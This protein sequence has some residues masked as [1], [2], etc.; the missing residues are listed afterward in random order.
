MTPESVAAKIHPAC[1]LAAGHPIPRSLSSELALTSVPPEGWLAQFIEESACDLSWPLEEKEQVIKALKKH[2]EGTY[3]HTA[4]LD[5]GLQIIFQKLRLKDESGRFVISKEKRVLILT[6]LFEDVGECTP[7]FHCRVNEAL[8]SLKPINTIEE[9][10]YHYRYQLVD[11]VARPISERVKWGFRVHQYNAVFVLA[12]HLQLGVIPPSLDDVHSQPLA[13]RDQIDLLDSFQKYYRPIHLVEAIKKQLRQ[14][15]GLLGYAGYNKDGYT[16]G[17][18]API[19]RYFATF[20]EI[21]LSERDIFLF[22][23]DSAIVDIQWKKVEESIVPLLREK[24]LLNMSDSAYRALE[25]WHNHYAPFVIRLALQDE[26][27]LSE[28]DCQ[29]AA[30]TGEQFSLVRFETA[31][32]RLCALDDFKDEY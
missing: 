6:R 16:L 20:L 24:E 28:E 12:S 17:V 13:D 1:Q 2:L 10:L 27:L 4:K 15:L 32:A 14:Q 19:K 30:I 25:V 18:F 31:L 3:T 23:E 11:K 29:R 9:H 26:L 8:Q 7:G 22:N 5:K 21:T